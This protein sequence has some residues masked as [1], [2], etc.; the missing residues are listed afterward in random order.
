MEEF[1]LIFVKFEKGI[2]LESL[3]IKL[4]KLFCTYFPVSGSLTYTN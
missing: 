2:F 1:L 3:P 4:I